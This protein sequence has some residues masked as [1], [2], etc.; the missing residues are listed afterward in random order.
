MGRSNW[1][2]GV[3]LMRYFVKLGDPSTVGWLTTG[4]LYA[5]DEMCRIT[6]DDG[7]CWSLYFFQK[8]GPQHIVAWDL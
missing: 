3:G 1:I 6:D 5:L 7:V 8:Y 4:R 2:C